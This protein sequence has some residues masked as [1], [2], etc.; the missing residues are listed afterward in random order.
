MLSLVA[1]L[2]SVTGAD[3]QS[4][5]KRM[6]AEWRDG[7]YIVRRYVVTDNASTN[8]NYEIHYAINSANT[9][10]GFEDNSEELARLD[11]FFDELQRD[12][13]IHIS[14]IEIVGYASPDGTTKFNSELARRRAQELS[15]MLAQRYNISNSNIAISSHVEP[16]SATSDAIEH[17]SLNNRNDLVRIVNSNEAP[18]T[19]DHKLKRENKAWSWLKSDVLP[20]MRKAT[21]TIAYTKDQITDKREYKPVASAPADVV[22]IE[23]FIVEDK[24]AKHHDKHQHEKRHHDGKHHGKH[25]KR[26]VVVL[27]EWEGVIIDMGAATEGCCPTSCK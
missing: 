23:E 5:N 18:M 27:N 6:L 26:N 16:W 8:Q 4:G 24:A 9:V 2:F 10:V 13:T 7:D 20:D 17:S 11:T 21:V 14:K 3:A 19:I 12:T 1:A 25:H 15:S 22:I